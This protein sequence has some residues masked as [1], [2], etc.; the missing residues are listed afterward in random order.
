MPKHV[1]ARWAAGGFLAGVFNTFW[2]IPYLPII[3]LGGMYAVMHFILW[4]P[5]LYLLL[6]NRPFMQGWSLYAVWSGLM[7]LAFLFSY[8]F[9]IRD[10]LV[11]L[12]YIWNL[13][14]Q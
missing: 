1:E 11:Y 12:P 9:D 8:I 10:T 3:S 6:K 5:G 2:V 14:F 4:T 7:T 13:H